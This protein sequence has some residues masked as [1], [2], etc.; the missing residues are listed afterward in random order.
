[1]SGAFGGKMAGGG[2]QSGNII[3]LMS[4]GWSCFQ[5]SFGTPP[6]VLGLVTVL[7][8]REVG[9]PTVEL[10]PSKLVSQCM[11]SCIT[12][13]DLI[14]LIMRSLP[15]HSV[16]YECVKSPPRLMEKYQGIHGHLFKTTMPLMKGADKLEWWRGILKLD[17][18]GFPFQ[19]YHVQLISLKTLSWFMKWK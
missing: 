9:H 5:F 7:W 4:G 11:T 19:F 17:S 15:L 3:T 18:Q 13:N 14:L 2:Y 8:L 12:F 6:S 10:R 1:M 16:G